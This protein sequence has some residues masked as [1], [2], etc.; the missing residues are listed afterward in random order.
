MYIYALTKLAYILRYYCS[1]QVFHNLST[2]LAK[3]AY[4]HQFFYIWGILNIFFIIYILPLYLLFKD[5]KKPFI[6]GISTFLG[7]Q[8]VSYI[9]TK[10]QL[11]GY[12]K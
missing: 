11:N 6:I 2:I 1:Y 3:V 8:K 9:T 12:K 5:T 4:N 7:L 10:N